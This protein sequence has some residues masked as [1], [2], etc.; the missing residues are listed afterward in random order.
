MVRVFA[1]FHSQWQFEYLYDAAL[2]YVESFGE[3]S[4]FVRPG[5]LSMQS[6][7]WP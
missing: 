5:G 6:E 2:K 3:Y 1:I 4:N 7:Q